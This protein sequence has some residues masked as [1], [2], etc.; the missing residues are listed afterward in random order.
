M[1]AIVGGIILILS[2]FG[3]YHQAQKIDEQERKVEILQDQL[4]DAHKATVDAVKVG[5]GNADLVT[6]VS[7]DLEICAG[8]LQDLT[9][10]QTTLERDY[11]VLQTD[12][13]SLADLVSATDWGRARIPDSVDF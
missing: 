2:L 12:F 4:T 1:E 5:N 11:Q 10:I 9:R 13:K 8:D 3:N 7:G 6:E